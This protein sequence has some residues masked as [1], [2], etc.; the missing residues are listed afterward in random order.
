ISTAWRATCSARSS[1]HCPSQCF[2][3]QDTTP[4][5]PYTLSLHDALPISIE[6]ITG[7]REVMTDTGRRQARVDA[8]EE[9]ARHQPEPDVGPCRSEEH[10]SELQ[11]RSEHVC[12][13]L[14]V[15]KKL[16]ESKL[17]DGGMRN[18]VNPH[19]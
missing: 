8:D 12:R 1:T 3:R 19:P 10:T 7:P 13:L 14:L 17:D 11:S 9:D 15:T 6:G 16:G 4:S 5:P 18:E 2:L